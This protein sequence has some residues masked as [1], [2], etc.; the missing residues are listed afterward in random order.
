VADR[1]FAGL[2]CSDVA[3]LAAAYVL[4][5]LDPAE[6]DAVRSHLE[7]CPEAHPA[8][9]ELGGVVPALFELVD[10]VEPPS[11]LRERIL[12]AAASDAQPAAQGLKDTQ[13]TEADPGRGGDPQ[14][15]RVLPRP[16]VDERTRGRGPGWLRR[17]IWA[18]LAAAASLAV[19][20]LAV[21]N[22]QLRNDV[23]GLTAY[24]DGVVAVLDKASQPGAQL[25]ILASPE[26][27]GPSGVAAISADGSV[28]MVMRD[29]APTSG[30][31]V[32]EAWLIA[33]TEAP[34]PIGGFQVDRSGTASFVTAHPTLGP[35]VTLALTREPGP[36]AS[37]PTLP[38]IAA[39]KAQSPAG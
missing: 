6:T 35:G 34:V 12:A 17:P 15:P 22:V 37:T 14:P 30:N 33:G 31:E 23:A 20:A 32:Y 27:G 10:P 4:G 39:G 25:A 9:A 7:L 24:R 18:G 29:L 11:G 1:E 38:I 16:T 19:I 13:A 2:R 3:D 26:A 5:A 21:W 28:A 8:M 36:G